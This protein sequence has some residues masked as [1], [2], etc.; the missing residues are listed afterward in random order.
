MPATISQSGGSEP[1]K[2]R[3]LGGIS[4]SS[5]QAPGRVLRPQSTISTSSSI[6]PTTASSASTSSRPL[7]THGLPSASLSPSHATASQSSNSSSPRIRAKVDLS[8]IVSPSSGASASSTSTSGRSSPYALNALRRAGSSASIP[9]SSTSAATTAPPRIQLHSSTTS[10]SSSRILPPADSPNVTIRKNRN[11]SVDLGGKVPATST[12][13][14]A[15][16]PTSGPF[17]NNAGAS[18]SS[19]SSSSSSSAS[20][21]QQHRRISSSSAS[22]SLVS[23]T[24]FPPTTTHHHSN[25]MALP[26]SG[27]SSISPASSPSRPL[28]VR[29]GST[30]TPAATAAATLMQPPGTAKVAKVT[31][32]TAAL[33]QIAPPPAISLAAPYESPIMEH[34]SLASPP[35]SIHASQQASGSGS[36]SPQSPT[37]SLSLPSPTGSSSNQYPSITH[38]LQQQQPSHADSAPRLQVDHPESGDNDA[39]AAALEAKKERKMLDLQIT[40]KSLLAINANLEK[41]RLK[42]SKEMREMRRKVALATAAAEARGANLGVAGGANASG[43]GGLTSGLGGFIAL[44]RGGRKHSADGIDGSISSSIGDG[45]IVSANGAGED[46]VDHPSGSG[47]SIRSPGVELEQDE[48]YWLHV[49]MAELTDE[50]D[51]EDAPSEEDEDRD[52]VDDS[53]VEDGEAE[54]T[55]GEDEKRIRARRRAHAERKAAQLV[56][57]WSALDAAHTRCRSLLD[58]MLLRGRLAVKLSLASDHAEIVEEVRREEEAASRLRELEREAE[59][60]QRKAAGTRVLH[61]VEMEERQREAEERRKERERQRELE[62]GAT[63]HDRG[64]PDTSEEKTHPGSTKTNEESASNNLRPPTLLLPPDDEASGSKT[65]QPDDDDARSDISSR[66]ERGRGRLSGISE[67]SSAISEGSELE[68]EPDLADGEAVGLG[69]SGRIGGQEDLGDISVD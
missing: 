56:R 42:L 9:T 12:I 65:S 4:S 54:M 3:V 14:H 66:T 1:P 48:N 47:S 22:S 69:T 5:S 44:L 64:I 50:E 23:T 25:S 20:R 39:A 26:H 37:T 45:S 19:A 40:N 68:L 49:A 60:E 10:P 62:G 2:R 11:Q 13:V 7:S 63:A 32:P 52:E 58:D 51:A 57:D 28:R 30:V 31:S 15:R 17:T 35:P 41:E 18:S 59:N 24:P 21:A 43:M 36:R 8:N 27:A 38:E 61:P 46:G 34:E 16:L 6:R 55:V 53:D 29:T 67:T 33:F